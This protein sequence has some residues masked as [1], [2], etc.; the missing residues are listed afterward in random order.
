[1]AAYVV[2][3]KY[4]WQTFWKYKAQRDR[5]RRVNRIL[6]VKDG[7]RPTRTSICQKPLE[8]INSA[9]SKGISVIV[10]GKRRRQGGNLVGLLSLLFALWCLCMIT[11]GG[12]GSF[13]SLLSSGIPEEFYTVTPPGH[14]LCWD[15]QQG[16]LG[17]RGMM[18]VDEE[19]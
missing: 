9:Y 3:F 18:Q 2:R 1:M 7:G 14:R 5:T 6:K 13:K 15:P 8:L 11:Y 4:W 10:G 17:W 12:G 16:M 19:L